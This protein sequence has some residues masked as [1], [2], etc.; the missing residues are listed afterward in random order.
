MAALPDKWVR[1][2]IYDR[3]HNM[4]IDPGTITFPCYTE[5]TGTNSGD[6]YTLLS[7]QLNQQNFSK[8]GSGWD[9]SCEVQ[10][11]VR[12]SK[13][14]GSKL[15][16]DNATDNVLTELADLSLD[17]GAGMKISE[18]VLDVVNEFS[19]ETTSKIVYRKIIRVQATIN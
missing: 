11:F 4:E 12:A 13:N 5:Q 14:E 2:A 18:L 10:V 17:A 8:C 19:D 16:I 9:H 6:Y 1:K 3:I 7:T 15:L